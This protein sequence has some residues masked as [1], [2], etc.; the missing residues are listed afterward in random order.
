[1][2]NATAVMAALDALGFDRDASALAISAFGGVRRR[3]DFIG[4]V[5]NITVIDDYGHHPTEVAATLKA[6]SELGYRRVHVLF[7]PHRYTRTR[8]LASEFARAFD[9]ADTI[10]FMEVYSA[11]EAPIPGVNSDALA[12]AVLEHNPVADVRVIKHRTDVPETMAAIAKPGD[13]VITMGAGDVTVL[14]PLV[15]EALERRVDGQ[16]SEQASERAP[17]QV[18]E[19]VPSQAAGQVSG[20]EQVPKRQNAGLQGRDD[21]RF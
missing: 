16:I 14:A 10:S 2:L 15:L 4:E 19:H 5:E 13:L 3:F 9:D 6:A 17:R 7:Q 8:A 21:A 18:P 1:M 12:E 20:Q 11:G